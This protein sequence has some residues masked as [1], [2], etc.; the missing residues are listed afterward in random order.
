VSVSALARA[1][2]PGPTVAVTVLATLL[3]VRADLTADRVVLVG[4]AVLTG[5][6][7]IGWTNDA[8]DAGRDRTVGR[9]DK[10][11]AT[12]EVSARTVATAAGVA[13]VACVALSAALGWRAAL[14]HLGL[15][16]GSGLAYDLGVKAT[17]WSWLPYAVAF[18]SLPA[19]PTLAQQPPAAPTWWTVA[20]GAALGVGAHL[21]N[22]LPDLDD[23]AATG[24]RGL[25]HRLGARASQVGAALLLLSASVVLVLGP[26]ADDGTGGTGN[27]WVVLLLTA[28]LAVGVAV[29]RGRTPFRLAVLMALV[30]V[31]L[32]TTVRSVQ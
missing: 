10:P 26:A 24:V 32:L 2:H 30:D 19:V 1:C 29:T 16:V 7:V 14:C 3:A 6:L 21:V 4:A 31:V 27:R 20:A 13:L 5:Q 18:G 23:D 8:V 15:L 11:V 25:P 12:G 17:A 28:A 9:A 22:V